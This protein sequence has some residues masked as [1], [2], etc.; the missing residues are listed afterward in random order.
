MEIIQSHQDENTSTPAVSA[1]KSAD[2]EN[3]VADTTSQVTPFTLSDNFP[4]STPQKPP[5]R[6]KD[7]FYGNSPEN[8]ETP[9]P[10]DI[11]TAIESLTPNAMNYIQTRIY[12]DIRNAF[13]EKITEYIESEFQNIFNMF[14]ESKL[15]SS[16]PANNTS[17]FEVS[18]MQM[19]PATTS[20]PQVNKSEVFNDKF[21]EFLGKFDLFNK[22]CDK[23]DTE[24]DAESLRLLQLDD[25][26][27]KLRNELSNLQINTDCEF[28][29]RLQSNPPLVAVNNTDPAIT[30]LQN[31]VHALKLKS[32]NQ[33]QQGRK[34]TIEIH[35][36]PVESHEDC[37]QVVLGFLA[38]HFGMRLQKADISVC[39]RQVIPS[40]KKLMGNHYIPPI[41]C[42][43]VNRYRARD[44]VQQF[45]KMKNPL[46]KFGTPFKVCEN[47]TFERRA[48]W[49]AV[50]T[51]LPSSTRKWIKNGKIF[52]KK[53]P[54]SFPTKVT[55]QEAL[56]RLLNSET[57][58][59]Q[60][61]SGGIQSQ[62]VAA[63][64]GGNTAQSKVPPPHYK[65][66]AHGHRAESNAL[67]TD[68]R[69]ST[70]A[71]VTEGNQQ[72]QYQQ[73]WYRRQPRNRFSQPVLTRDRNSVRSP[74]RISERIDP[75]YFCGPNQRPLSS[76][77]HHNRFSILNN[78]SST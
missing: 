71:G 60:G 11:R 57:I 32:D 12:H 19:N 7:W 49:E 36:I 37:Y 73:P 17:V 76:F 44:I 77:F 30:A 15:N 40:D 2:T 28:A 23:I 63:A 56:D 72:N 42:K 10:A 16:I 62:N 66:N 25:E 52:L 75:G 13:N 24:R 20:H 4:S 39:H 27:K 64:D 78:H 35:G 38:Y 33:E 18:R 68:Y 34:E 55:S 1:I 26:I 47:L 5:L 67:P 53:S 22:K 69:F 59:P 45:N 41:Y 29:N 50:G 46:T 58:Q 14:L 3:E 70:Y 65:N 74:H 54:S 43:L 48:L 61:M 6:I 8:P 51:K 9:P 31:D 21:N